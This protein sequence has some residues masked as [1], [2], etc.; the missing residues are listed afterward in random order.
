MDTLCCRHG[1]MGY[2][3]FCYQTVIIHDNK[4]H[5]KQQ[6]FRRKPAVLIN[7]EYKNISEI[8]YAIIRTRQIHIYL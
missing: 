8:K 6:A 3:N 2:F 7:S 4:N 5:N 1:S